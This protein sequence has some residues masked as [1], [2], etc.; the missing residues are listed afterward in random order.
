[1]ARPAKT[2]KRDQQLNLKLTRREMAWVR[3]AAEVAKME[4]VDFGRARLLSDAP[5]LAKSDPWSQEQALLRIQLGRLGN[6][7]N[8]IARAMNAH[9]GVPPAE[10]TSLLADIR[11]VFERS[12]LA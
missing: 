9:G 3:A 7:L 5:A 12:A 10:L 8:Q 11:A 1:M 4:P 2:E 6:N